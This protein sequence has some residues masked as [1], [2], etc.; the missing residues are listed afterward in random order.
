MD[1]W[2]DGTLLLCLL[3]LSLDGFGM[4]GLAQASER[5]GHGRRWGSNR[6]LWD[7][8]AFT[9]LGAGTLVNFPFFC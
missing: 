9:K 2:E 5:S 7:V 4:G 3:G 6:G 8:N 1:G